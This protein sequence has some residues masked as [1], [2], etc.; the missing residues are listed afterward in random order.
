MFKNQFSSF[1]HSEEF[2]SFSTPVEFTTKVKC[3]ACQFLV[4]QL[5]V[6]LEDL[7]HKRK[8]VLF[9]INRHNMST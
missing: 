8:V 5:G 6:S 9:K 4:N 1:M 7:G 2:C 3:P